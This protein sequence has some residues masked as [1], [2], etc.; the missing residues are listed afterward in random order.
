MQL[1][2][3][4]FWLGESCFAPSPV[5][6]CALSSV[7]KWVDVI[8]ELATRLLFFLFIQVMR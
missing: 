6:R 3:A 2:Q 7:F 8:G 4:S 1:L 5:K